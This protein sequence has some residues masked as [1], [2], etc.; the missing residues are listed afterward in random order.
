[1]NIINI[2]RSIYAFTSG[3]G[4]ITCGYIASESPSFSSTALLAGFAGIGF[5]FVFIYY[6]IVHGEVEKH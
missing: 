4:I 6:L 2:I 1:M 5:S 3:A